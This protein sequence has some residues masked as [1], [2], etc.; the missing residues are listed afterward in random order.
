MMF[1]NVDLP[2]PDLPSIEIN[3]EL[4]KERLMLRNARKERLLLVTYRFD[5]F[6]NLINSIKKS[7]YLLIKTLFLFNLTKIFL[8]L[9]DFFIF[10]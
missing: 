7:L 8:F 4:G 9:L 1:N 3:P 2:H 5:T 6:T 10:H